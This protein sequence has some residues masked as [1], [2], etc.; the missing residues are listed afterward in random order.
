MLPTRAA[1]GVAVSLLAPLALAQANLGE[2]LDAGGK[3]LS[4]Q[5]FEEQLVQRML[6]GPSATGLPLE[7]IY[8]TQG[9]VVG[10]G[11]SPSG[12]GA[13]RFSG[14]WRIDASGKVCATMTV[15]GVPGGGG[16]GPGSVILPERCQSWYKL[17]ERYFL[18]DSDT[19]RSIRVLVRT[20]KQ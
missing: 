2:L 20:L 7:M 19:D 16:P 9:S 12:L 11:T 14:Q 6:I 15:G 1:L 17:G 4:A 3:K 18:A 5:D 13:T 10:S 8:T